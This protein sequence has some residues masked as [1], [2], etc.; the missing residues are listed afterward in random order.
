MTDDEALKRGAEAGYALG[1]ALKDIIDPKQL[2]IALRAAM[3][4][5]SKVKS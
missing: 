3:V 5:M 1:L 2:E 4:A